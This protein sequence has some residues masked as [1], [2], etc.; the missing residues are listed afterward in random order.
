MRV[1]KGLAVNFRIF[2]SSMLP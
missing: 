1:F 2:I